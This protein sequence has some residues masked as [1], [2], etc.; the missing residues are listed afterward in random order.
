MEA[1]FVKHLNFLFL[2][3]FMFFCTQPGSDAASA[4]PAEGDRLPEIVLPAPENRMHLTYLGL[5]NQNSFTIP[6]IEARLIIIEIFSM[7]CPHCQREAPT[8]NR[9]Y[10]MIKDREDIKLIG[11]G[12]GNS[13]FEVNAF[14]ETYDIEFPLFSDEDWSIHEQ[15]GKCR[16]PYFIALKIL[17]DG[18]D[19]IVFAQLGGIKEKDYQKFLETIIKRAGLN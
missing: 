5:K 6:E 13:D 18:T 7:Y 8:V 12:V 11:I 3:I 19:R 10:Q 14:K 1:L 2:L 15:L 9:L 17:P 16:T 4:P